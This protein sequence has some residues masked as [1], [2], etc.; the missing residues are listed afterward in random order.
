MGRTELPE[1]VLKWKKPGT[2]VKCIGG[3]YY[4][5][6]ATSKRV[7]GKAWPV[8][9]QTYVGRI[10]EGGVAEAGVRIEPSLTRAATLRELSDS[11]PEGCGDE[12]FILVDGR[13]HLTLVGDAVRT[14][15]ESDGIVEDGVLAVN[16]GSDAQ[17]GSGACR[18]VGAC[19][20]GHEA[21]GR[22]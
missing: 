15:L 17:E 22:V 7:P 8:S 10:T 3:S 13:W 14:R 16:E 19:K 20:R 6:K 5:Y 12:I 11:C 2:T 1:W 21:A 9:V 18:A 4:L